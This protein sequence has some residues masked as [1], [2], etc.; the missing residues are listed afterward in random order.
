MA[1][2]VV[3]YGAGN[4]KSAAKALIAAAQGTRAELR[5]TADPDAVRKAE[6]IVLPGVGAFADCKHGIESHPGLVEAL[7]EAVIRKGQ[8]FLG[9]CVGMQLMATT[10]IE[11]GEHAGLDWVKGKV[12]RLTPDDPDLKIP[13]IGWNDLEAPADPHP[14]L[15]GIG[16]GTD[17]YFVHSYHFVAEHA[18]DVLARIDYGG[19]VTAAIGRDN[20]V[21]VQ[22][23]PEKSQAA[24][25]KLLSNFLQWRP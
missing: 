24:G 21:G 8:P 13:Q 11:Y 3:D 2:I 12:V 25:L 15:A 1:V 19:P 14:V 16:T 4:L 23:H 18:A 10:G 9:I 6:R 7:N 5:V 20:M 17:V 22:F